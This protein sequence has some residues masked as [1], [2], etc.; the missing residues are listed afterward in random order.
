MY[1]GL[2]TDGKVWVGV[3]GKEVAANVERMTQK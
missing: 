2:R 3:M 1:L